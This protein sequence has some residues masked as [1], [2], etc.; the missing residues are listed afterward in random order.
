M[1][2]SPSG[3]LCIV[4]CGEKPGEGIWKALAGS[5]R[6]PDAEAGETYNRLCLN[7]LGKILFNPLSL[8]KNVKVKHYI[9]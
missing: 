9:L 7:P 6:A 8:K 3:L 5:F 4:S 2:R 1:E